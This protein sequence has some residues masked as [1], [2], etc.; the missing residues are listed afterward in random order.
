MIPD[1]AAPVTA[2]FIH[3]KLDNRDLYQTDYLAKDAMV[4]Q[5]G[6]SA[7]TTGR[8]FA[9]AKVVQHHQ[10]RSRASTR[11]RASAT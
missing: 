8:L 1:Q 11:S 7:S 6:Q 9:G 2:S 3:T 4:V 10:L 5:P